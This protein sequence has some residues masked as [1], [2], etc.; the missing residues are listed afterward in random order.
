MN[1]RYRYILFDWDGTIA[2][3]LDIWL[4]ALRVSLEKHGHFLSDKEIGANYEIF[5]KHFETRER[6]DITPIINEAVRAADNNIPSVELYPHALEVLQQLQSANKRLALVTT[7]RHA[8]IDPLL[9]KHGMHSLFHAVVCGDDTERI[10]PD[11]APIKRVLS[12]LGA[13]S[14]ETLIIGDSENDI[15]AA[16]NAGIDSVLFY[17]KA[18]ERFHNIQELKR[19][20][21][22]FIIHDLREIMRLV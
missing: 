3:T 15:R 20:K 7:S 11:A 5:K 19:F 2:K 22:T 18:H 4:D 1:R 13:N 12:K 8:Q 21:P 17:P 16:A 14:D 9:K 10:K 6:I